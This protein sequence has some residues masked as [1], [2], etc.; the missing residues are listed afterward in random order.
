[1]AIEKH[2][3]SYHGMHGLGSCS[4]G[5]VPNDS[6][7]CS[8][9]QVLYNQI[10]PSAPTFNTPPAFVPTMCDPRDSSCVVGNVGSSVAY[11]Q[12]NLMAQSDYNYQVCLEQLDSG[13]CRARWPVGYAG[14]VPYTN[15]SPAMQQ[16]NMATPA[17][18]AGIYLA[19]PNNANIPGLGPNAVLNAPINYLKTL[20][21]WVNQ[22]VNSNQTNVG[23]TAP[24][25]S[26]NTTVPGTVKST[27]QA[28]EQ[29]DNN[30]V[31][32]NPVSRVIAGI[33][34]IVSPSEWGNIFGSGDILAIAGLVGVPVL[35]L[36][37]MSRKK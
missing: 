10:Q 14:E 32:D 8:L 11:I 31:G 17:Q 4:P 20:G 33:T 25:G 21:D 29:P 15:L 22:L 12:S 30:V 26:S 9:S 7:G 27:V 35:A 18:A 3:Y 1:M 24:G 19:N 6:G 28:G 23:G 37:F 16:A 2:G 36:G 13:T 34:S 5:F